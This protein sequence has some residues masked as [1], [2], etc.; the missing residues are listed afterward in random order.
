[1]ALVPSGFKLFK[2]KLMAVEFDLYNFGDM[3]EANSYAQEHFKSSDA[4]LKLVFTRKSN[5][6]LPMLKLW[7]MWMS[8]IADFKA[9]RGS[10]M[11]LYYN[12]QGNPIGERKFNAHDA[13]EAY[14]YLCLGCDS[15]GNR[16]SWALSGDKYDNRKVADLGQRLRAMQKFHEHCLEHSIPIRIPERNEYSELI[17]RQS[18]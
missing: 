1:M 9:A 10:V 2:A 17:E 8:D 12:E 18:Q 6:T 13:H 5:G 11:P 3:K 14:T 16:Y 15:E 7:R 4:P